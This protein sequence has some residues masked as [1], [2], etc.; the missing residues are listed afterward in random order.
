MLQDFHTLTAKVGANCHIF[1]AVDVKH[2]LWDHYGLGWYEEFDVTLVAGEQVKDER[3]YGPA[4]LRD[5][6]LIYH[7]EA[8]KCQIGCPCQMCRMK[9]RDCD[10]FDDHLTFHL[11]NHTMCKYCN[12][13]ETLVTKLLTKDITL[14][15]Q[16]GMEASRVESF[17][18]P[19]AVSHCSN[20]HLGIALGNHQEKI[21]SLTVINVTRSLKCFHI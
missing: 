11:S 2:R 10:D 16:L 3:L 15:L 13:D 21:L 5:Q 18:I 8:F 6:T 14:A 17:T 20:T 1:K 4:S 9:L 19:W 12:E 7:C